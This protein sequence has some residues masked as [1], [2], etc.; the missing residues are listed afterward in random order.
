MRTS[1]TNYDLLKK[2]N[3]KMNERPEQERLIASMDE[4]IQS[5]APMTLTAEAPTGIGKTVA[6]LVPGLTALANRDLNQIIISTATN[7]LS[8]QIMKKD[9]P[10]VVKGLGLRNIKAMQ[11]KGFKNYVC[12]EKVKDDLIFAAI[13]A[14]EG[15]D[16]KA[17]RF[18]QVV[19]SRSA[20]QLVEFNDLPESPSKASQSLSC[21]DG[22]KK[23]PYED[24]ACRFKLSMDEL[25]TADI[26]VTNH[27]YLANRNGYMK[28][29]KDNEDGKKQL[30][31]FDEAH[32]LPS[33]IDHMQA[34][35]INLS[36]IARASQSLFDLAGLEDA[37]AWVKKE[38][39]LGPS[40][41]GK[42]QIVAAAIDEIS[43][44]VKE[45]QTHPV[46]NVTIKKGVDIPEE[47]ETRI[48]KGTLAEGEYV[49]NQ[50]LLDVAL[51]R[52]Y[53]LAKSIERSTDR[54]RTEMAAIKVAVHERGGLPTDEEAR[55]LDIY[56]SIDGALGHFSR[57]Y[58]RY[59][60]D[61]LMNDSSVRQYRDVAKVFWMDRGEQNLFFRFGC[62]VGPKSEKGFYSEALGGLFDS[63]QTRIALL[64][65]TLSASAIK[66]Y[67]EPF[68]RKFRL[69]G[70]Q[71]MT[72]FAQQSFDFANNVRLAAVTSPVLAQ[73]DYKDPST[74][75]A[76]HGEF[77]GFLSKSIPAVDGGSLVL[78]TNQSHMKHVANEL[79]GVLKDEGVQ[80]IVQGEEP[81]TR[82]LDEMRRIPIDGKK[83]VLFGV[84][85]AW[86][87]VD[88][89]GECCRGLFIMKVPFTNPNDPIGHKREEL[90][91]AAKVS[92]FRN[93]QI[94]DACTMLRQG[95]GRLVRN[96]A[97]YGTVTILDHRFS[98]PQDKR[99]GY[100]AKVQE[101]FPIPVQTVGID[102]E[103]AAIR[104]FFE[105]RA[106]KQSVGKV[107]KAAQPTQATAQG[108]KPVNG[109]S[110]IKPIAEQNPKLIDIPEETLDDEDMMSLSL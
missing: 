98:L 94:P 64:S 36:L 30:V 4:L 32:N 44:R 92:Y 15:D 2:N 10:D 67:M 101:S 73:V 91:D 8:D 72:F 48:R 45:H 93:K 103:A 56:A 6:Y 87:G 69:G 107:V 63:K 108:R 55:L 59:G 82:Q 35:R 38:D 106:L 109:A 33:I 16:E 34:G 22:T 27:Y 88:L 17:S 3:P 78:F 26:I 42:L 19:N 7:A 23:C 75:A 60:R 58:R 61:R 14:Y 24:T 104:Q 11:L 102:Q 110:A 95:F 50:E 65:A 99:P 29:L 68:I 80:V 31:I 76:M 1:K 71:E 12:S 105:E 9:I 100:L 66:S 81:I 21:C 51:S 74:I 83:R 40:V 37:P 53:G 43:N 79:R 39:Y 52:F 25:S 62:A 13:Q 20:T 28:H 57:L 54:V 70:R 49:E 85:T 5:D 41:R 18:R 96:E 47:I 86:Q 97:D 89:P 90:Y 46:E 77:V 84:D